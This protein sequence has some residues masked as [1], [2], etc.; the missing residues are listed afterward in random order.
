MFDRAFGLSSLVAVG[1]HPDARN[2][3]ILTTRS[4][5]SPGQGR[6]AAA[7]GL[8]R[9]C[10]APAATRMAFRALPAPGAK[11][12]PRPEWRERARVASPQPPGAATRHWRAKAS[13]AGKPKPAPPATPIG[14]NT[15]GHRRPAP[16]RPTEPPTTGA[17]HPRKD[18]KVTLWRVRQGRSGIGPEGHNANRASL[19]RP[20]GQF[21]LVRGHSRPEFPLFRADHQ[22]TK[23]PKMSLRAS[24]RHSR[25][26]GRVRVDPATEWRCVDE[27]V[28]RLVARR[29]DC[30]RRCRD[31]G[32]RYCSRPGV[33]T[34]GG[35]A[36]TGAGFGVRG[37]TLL[38]VVVVR[39]G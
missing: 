11:G 6:R 14:T 34:A 21:I 23:Y 22:I 16:A 13:A 24:T 10:P 37:P 25:T 38:R 19:A 12:A 18:G 17:N 33:K 15:S 4:R 3:R 29:R 28:A 26:L 32:R 1:W 27:T 5:P 30:G 36:G 9:L 20:Q 7:P 31:C 2:I 35:G 39:V 8:P